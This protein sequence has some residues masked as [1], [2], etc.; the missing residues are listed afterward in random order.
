MENYN[1]YLKN[2]SRKLRK[3]MTETEVMIWN[4]LRRKQINGLQFY[5]QKP[6]GKYIVDFYCPAKKLV[7]EI[8]GGQHFWNDNPEKDKERDK[9]LADALG[10]KILRFTNV[11]IFQNIEGVVHKIIEVIK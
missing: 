6:L 9:Y 11:D 8:D 5:R 3:G 4:R 10:Y 2:R 1:P 7:I